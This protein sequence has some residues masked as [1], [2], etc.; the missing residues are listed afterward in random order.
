VKGVHYNVALI[1]ASGNNQHVTGGT[2]ALPNPF[3]GSG[4][5]LSSHFAVRSGESHSSGDDI[6]EHRGSY[7]AAH[8]IG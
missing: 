7:W 8:R 3:T 6:D 1:L 5:L 4:R 2:F